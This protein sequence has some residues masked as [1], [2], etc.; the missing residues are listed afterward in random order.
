MVGLC[1][2]VWR[3]MR[4]LH[5]ELFDKKHPNPWDDFTLKS[6]TKTKKHAVTRE[7]VYKFAW[8]CIKEG[9]P[10]PAAVAVICFEW[11]QRPENVVAGFLTWPDYRSKNWPHAVRIEHHK[12]KA[13]VWHP[14]EENSRRRE[15]QVLCRSRGRLGPSAQARRPND[16][17]SDRKG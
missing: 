17:A 13:L 3:I 7:E 14:L 15:R 16:H 12:N 4:R 8:G 10:E 2:K 5:P 9:R 6:R 11:L 1:R